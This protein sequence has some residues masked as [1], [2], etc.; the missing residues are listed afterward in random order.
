[1]AVRAMR[2]HLDHVLP[3]LEITRRLRPEYFTV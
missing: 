1:R 2:E 3:V